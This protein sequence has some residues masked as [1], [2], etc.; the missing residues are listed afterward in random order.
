MYARRALPAW[1]IHLI[2]TWNPRGGSFQSSNLVLPAIRRRVN[3]L[4]VMTL[5]FV[6]SPVPYKRVRASLCVYVRLYVCCVREAKIATWCVWDRALGTCSVLFAYMHTY[7][8]CFMLKL[9]DTTVI[10]ALEEFERNRLI[11]LNFSL[12]RR[13]VS[14][15]VK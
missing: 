14:S 10:I 1:L 13:N 11:V 7:S 15:I 3:K 12:K 6:R 8:G 9:T 2:N 5:Q 4:A